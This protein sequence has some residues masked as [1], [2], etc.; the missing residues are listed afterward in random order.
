MI[1]LKNKMLHVTLCDMY[2]GESCCHGITIEAVGC[3]HVIRK[4]VTYLSREISILQKIC[5]RL[6]H[7]LGALL[8]HAVLCVTFMFP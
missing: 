2:E 5:N 8:H 4:S 3:C 1:M 6:G 7:S